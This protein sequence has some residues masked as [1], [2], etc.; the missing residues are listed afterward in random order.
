MTEEGRKGG[1]ERK[2]SEEMQNPFLGQK[3]LVRM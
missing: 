1:R 3:G 2:K